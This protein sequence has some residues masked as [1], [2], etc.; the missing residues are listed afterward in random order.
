LQDFN[1]TCFIKEAKA[2]DLACP[3][4][5]A[6]ALDVK[7]DSKNTIIVHILKGSLIKGKSYIIYI[8]FTSYINLITLCKKGKN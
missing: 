2:Y 4:K 3:I 6:K 1:Y 8:N 7:I 5:E